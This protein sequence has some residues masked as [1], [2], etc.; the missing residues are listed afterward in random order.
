MLYQNLI[1]FSVFI[2]FVLFIISIKKT[3]GPLRAFLIGL[4][5][6]ALL[7]P[8]ILSLNPKKELKKK[9]LHYVNKKIRVFLDDSKSMKKK[10][11]SANS[12][13]EKS[14]KTIQHLEDS[15]KILPCEIQVSNMSHISSLTEKGYSPIAFSLNHF[16]SDNT[17]S[18]SLLL[19]DAEDYLPSISYEEKID[20]NLIENREN[21]KIISFES[22]VKKNIWITDF[23][24]P[25]LGFYTKKINIGFSIKRSGDLEKEALQVQILSDSK[26]LKTKTVHLH[27][28][29]QEINET[30]SLEALQKGHHLLTLKVL[31]VEGESSI[32]DNISHQKIEILP[33]TKGILHLLGSPT[34]DGRFLRRHLKSEPKYDLISFYIL[35]NPGDKQEASGRELSLIPFPVNRL[36]TEE[37]KNFH[38]IIMQNFSLFE[39][40]SKKYQRNLVDFVKKGGGLLFMGGPKA[41]SLQDLQNSPLKEIFPLQL[42]N[43]QVASP[44]LFSFSKTYSTFHE[45]ESFTIQ[46][47]KPSEEQINFATIYH[48]F[49]SL[50][51][52]LSS[53]KNLLGLHEFQNANLKNSFATPLL[54][55]L[56]KKNQSAPLALASYP[57][58]GRALW[59]L[60]DSLWKLAFNPNSEAPRAL[61]NKL[62]SKS[63]NW[64]LRSESLKPLILKDLRAHSKGKEEVVF[65]GTLEGASVKYIS[66]KDAKWS[67]S[68]CG[69]QIPRKNIHLEIKGEHKAFLSTTMKDSLLNK[70]QCQMSLEIKHPSFGSEKIKSVVL[71][72]KLIKDEDQSP[73]REIPESLA[74]VLSANLSFYHEME[75]NELSEWLKKITEENKIKSTTKSEWKENFFWPLGIPYFFL[76]L[77]L[78]PIEVLIRKWKD[79]F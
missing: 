70:N 44:S 15:C 11:I 23:N 30:M 53:R 41:L 59:F 3:Y 8:I 71:L 77:L 39:F 46:M 78:I 18:A 36:F 1:Y 13:Y 2:I 22:E 27:P 47:A 19:T 63:I 34:W 67:L 54:N 55:S 37:L 76:L 12:F 29:S 32:H 4:C 31:P 49:Y 73:K 79:L 43:K 65:K 60:T 6:F 48:D 72:P 57:E 58:K 25:K 5:R 75:S 74:R 14:L 42:K 21:I 51:E 7:L 52:N 68:F 38:L 69:K 16:F 28:G 50:K 62:I 24:L 40:M 61:Y 35:R 17:E 64:L 20:S 26:V 33:N 45:K 10:D 66:S 9:N 56:N